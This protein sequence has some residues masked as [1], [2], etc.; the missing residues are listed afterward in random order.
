MQKYDVLPERYRLRFRESKIRIG[1]SYGEYSHYLSINFDRW[2]KAMGVNNDYEGLKQLLLLEKFLDVVS[3]D[4]K[5]HLSESRVSTLT[6]AARKADDYTLLHKGV[7]PNK[8]VA[9]G[10][11]KQSFQTQ[12]HDQTN[13]NNNRNKGGNNNNYY[14]PKN[15]EQCDTYNNNNNNSQWTKKETLICYN[16]H[17]PNHKANQCTEPKRGNVAYAN[18]GLRNTVAEL[19]ILNE[20]TYM[21]NRVNKNTNRNVYSLYAH[22]R[23]DKNNI[24]ACMSAYR[25]TGASVSILR[26]GTVPM[27]CLIPL[28]ETI[29]L[30]SFCE[31]YSKVPMYRVRVTSEIVKNECSDIEVAL[32]PEWF[33]WPLNVCIIIGEDFGKAVGLIN[34]VET[35]TV[36]TRSIA[37]LQNEEKS[38]KPSNITAEVVL[39][40]PVVSASLRDLS[41]DRSGVELGIM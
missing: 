23:V 40:G 30:Q 36:V 22:D 20:Q 17:K 14:R 18:V 26:E 2:T 6:E 21:C 34:N 19:T 16:C 15:R 12:A 10:T 5:I 25:D 37:R 39:G 13:S 8:A 24:I 3:N 29:D 7:R 27:K 32:A 4:L 11:Q 35:V 41:S 33:N 38:N 28:N 9:S 31:T 1:E